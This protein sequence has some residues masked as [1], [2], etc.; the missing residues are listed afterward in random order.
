MDGSQFSVSFSV[1]WVTSQNPMDNSNYGGGRR[2][3]CEETVTK[4]QLGSL[5]VVGS[6]GKGRRGLS[7]PQI[8]LT[9]WALP[10]SVGPRCNFWLVS[11]ERPFSSEST[12]FPPQ[13]WNL[14]FRSSFRLIS[15]SNGER[16]RSSI[17]RKQLYQSAPLDHVMARIIFV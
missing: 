16:R 11:W 17:G 9:L 7:L 12:P 10:V 14:S 15:L 8:V 2:L 13:F 1:T 6:W 3:I 4:W 5:E